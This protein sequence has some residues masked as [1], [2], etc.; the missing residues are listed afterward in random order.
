MT[1]F[2]YPL[3]LEPIPVPKVWGGGKLAHIKGRTV[4]EGADPIGE[5]WDVSTWPTAPD[6][7]NQITVTRIT[8]GPLAGTPLD[9]VVDVPVVAKVID[10]A[11][12]LSVQNHPVLENVHKD[13]MWYILQADE[14]AYLYL[15]L[16]EGVDKE[17]FCA[18]LRIE[19]PDE[20]T[21]LGMMNKRAPIVAGSYFNVPTGTVHAIGPGL[22]T[23]EISEKTQVTY[24]LYDY[25]RERS[26]GK[27]DLDEGCRAIT[28]PRPD[29]PVLDHGL[30]LSGASAM[31][32][33]TEFPTFCVARVTGGEITVLSS[34]H[35]SL[36]TAT[37]GD[38][39]ISD[40]GK[41]WDVELGYSFTCLAPP[42]ET[43][44]VIDTLGS[45]EVLI[46]PLRGY[47][48]SHFASSA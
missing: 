43:P 36:I 16:A 40:P 4:P 33:I 44:Y 42:V 34:E 28:T 37:R 24:R 18:L 1:G 21:I 27:L 10:S 32:I 9:L 41:N 13:E 3:L 46:S 5:S 6:N 31:E 22:L 30:V 12:R 2:D 7:P 15:D 29:L 8:N 14:G 17:E 48:T 26:R 25:N 11:D 20:P 19:N 23:F 47:S 45:G 38:I 39:R 35:M